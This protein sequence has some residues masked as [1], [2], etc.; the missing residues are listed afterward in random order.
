[1]EI[2][3][4]KSPQKLQM[5]DLRRIM[6][7]FDK[8]IKL[9]NDIDYAH[10]T[11]DELFKHQPFML[12]MLMGYKLDLAKAELNEV[13]NLYITIWEYFKIDPILKI[14]AITEAQFDRIHESNIEL[15]A[16]KK[17]VKMKVVPVLYAAILQRFENHPVLFCMEP[18]PKTAVMI[19]AKSIIECFQEL[20]T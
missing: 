10:L 19:G 12:S 9:E 6:T 1:M 7:I 18:H 13:L 3:T 4:N 2:I 20:T 11:T 8:I 5:E 14:K 17:T 16:T 15:F